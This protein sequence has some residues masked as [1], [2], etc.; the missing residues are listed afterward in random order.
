M[1][2]ISPLDS[3]YFEKIK[4]VAKVFS[5]VNFTKSKLLVEC[6]YIKTVH[7][8]LCDEMSSNR[9]TIE[10]VLHVDSICTNF[11][12][13]AYTRIKQIETITNHDI[14]ALVQYCN[15]T[16]PINARKFIHYGLT[17]QDINSPAMMLLYKKF[18]TNILVYSINDILLSLLNFE[19]QYNKTPMLTFT[20]GQPAMPSTFGLQMMV[21]YDKINAIMMDISN[22]KYMTKF[23][24]SNGNLTSLKYCYK[25]VDWDEF[26]N[27]FITKF[28][29]MRNIHTTQIDDYSN[30][31]KLFQLYE[32]LCYVLINMCQDMW[33]YCHNNYF[34]L[35]NVP[36]EVG[37]SAMPHKINPIQFENAEGNLKL[38][39]SMFNTIGSNICVNRLQRDL[40]DSTILR[41]VGVACG[42]MVLG[43]RSIDAGLNRISLNTNVINKDLCENNQV[44]ME[45]IQLLMRKW[46]I[47]NGYTLCKDFSRGKNKLNMQE[48]ITYLRE[49]QIALNRNQIYELSNISYDKLF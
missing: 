39:A 20:H 21:F 46:N 47:S 1:Y 15:E 10:D 17:S 43:L 24:G 5:D 28:G 34:K 2:C 44:L 27:T 6:E 45:I 7:P 11:N 26:A 23:G 22:F 35:A 33:L 4:D 32:R 41:N 36:T 14:Q 48:F 13:I 42:H 9:M 25:D 40:T 16:F 38:A 30:Y 31:F 12:D 3:R 49:K 37:S 18:N 19:Q 8:I 29:F